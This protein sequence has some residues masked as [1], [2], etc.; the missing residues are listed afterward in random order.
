MWNNSLYWLYKRWFPHPHLWRW[1]STACS[2]QRVV[3]L[4]IVHSIPAS[5]SGICD[6][7]LARCSPIPTIV[8][9][10]LFRLFCKCRNPKHKRQAPE[11]CSRD[12]ILKKLSKYLN[13]FRCFQISVEK[14][15]LS[16]TLN[17]S[18][19]YSST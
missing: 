1:V 12:Q 15:I 14:V 5:R 9:I 3:L 8:W 4:L 6:H 13:Y 16:K 11:F 10:S 18:G 19:V 7:S 2:F 17:S